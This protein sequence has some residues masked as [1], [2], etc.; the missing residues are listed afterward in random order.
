MYYAGYYKDTIE[1]TLA[2]TCRG[3][4]KLPEVCDTELSHKTFSCTVPNLS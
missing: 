4:R 1:G 2:P 3:G